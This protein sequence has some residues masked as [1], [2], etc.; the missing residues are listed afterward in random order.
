MASG[1][2]WSGKD[3]SVQIPVR[4]ILPIQSS[5]VL[6]Y[7]IPQFDD[8]NHAGPDAYDTGLSIQNFSAFAVNVTC[9]YT[10]NQCYKE[11]GLSMAFTKA[12]PANG[13]VRFSL[14][15]ELLLAGYPAGLNSEGHVEITSDVAA[16]LFPTACIATKDYLF[17]AGQDFQ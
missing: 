9:R 10:V 1:G 12:I 11:A 6:A 17:S 4:K 7:A 14:L 15:Q 8:V 16:R 3:P 13:G 5:W 2:N